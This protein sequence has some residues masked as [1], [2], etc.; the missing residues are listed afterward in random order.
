M[1]SGRRAD[2]AVQ[3]WQASGAV[4]A[5]A[6][7]LAELRSLQR[8]AIAVA[9]RAGVRQRV[10]AFLADLSPGRVSQIVAEERGRQVDVAAVRDALNTWAEW[11]G[12]RLKELQAVCTEDEREAW[13]RKYELA[14][15]RPG[16]L[17]TVKAPYPTE[18]PAEKCPRIDWSRHHL[19]DQTD[20]P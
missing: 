7:Q 14:H 19:A 9:A 2:L 8:A 1:D 18:R 15:G 16:S 10:L 13:N 4:A 17:G 11:P 20:S 12:D 3:A 6:A 5:V